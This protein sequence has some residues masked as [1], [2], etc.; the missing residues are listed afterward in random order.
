V[1]LDDDGH[2]HAGV[3]LEARFS[4]LEQRRSNAVALPL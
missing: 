2:S 1:R 3:L 4:L